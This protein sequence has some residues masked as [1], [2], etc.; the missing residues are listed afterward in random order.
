[1]NSRKNKSIVVVLVIG[2]LFL[3]NYL[4]NQFFVRLDFTEDKRFTL[5]SATKD[6]L[7]NLDE[8]VTITAYFS[9]N[10]PPQLEQV[11]R[12][13]RDMLIEYSNRSK[14]MVAFEFIDPLKDD[15]L[16]ARA[17]Q[18]GIAQTQVQVEEKDQVKAQIAFMGATIQFGEDNEPIP[19]IYTTV[20]L[21]YK[22]SS[23]IKKLAIANKPVVGFVQGHGETTFGQIWQAKQA[24]DVLHNTELVYLNDSMLV[25]DKYRTLAII[26]PKDSIP[27]EEL[28]RLDNFLNRGGRL[29]IAIN[30]SDADLASE[31][32]S[33]AV[34]TGL[35]TWLAQ[36]GIDVNSNVVIDINCQQGWIQ[37]QPGYLMQITIPYFIIA[38]NFSDH[39]ISSGLEQ[40]TLNFASS[41]NHSGDSSVIFTPLIKSSE[42]SGTKPAA[43]YID[44]TQQWKEPD[45]PI[46]SLTL[47]AALEG[48]IA[49]SA[50]TKMVIVGDADFPVG[51]GQQ[52]QVNPDNIN[53]LV[54][55]IDWL[56]DDTGLIELR[57]RGATARPIDDLEENKRAFLKYL[58]FL[59]PV[60]LALLYGIFRFQRNRIIR[61]KRM[62]E[63]Y[64]Q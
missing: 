47:A 58:N 1:M 49:G 59:L 15:K 48:S 60:I 22:L 18:A 43:G 36:K 11:K 31:Q 13:F 64:V 5:S 44:I 42:H 7:N 35:E 12:D 28:T 54:N 21:E 39:P 45:F 33:R 25:L 17:T 53:F 37:P 46:S 51:E 24:L 30:R 62:E 3:L 41:L 26:G 6:L 57:T 34:N 27:Y 20:G 14:G 29:F 52:N 4:S 56:S 16:K 61:L 9:G 63:G 19:N 10:L 32:Y 55:S 23:A 38:Q 50:P 8:P 2:I 40:L